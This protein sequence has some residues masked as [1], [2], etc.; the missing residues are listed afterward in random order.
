[1]GTKKWMGRKEMDGAQINGCVQRFGYVEC[2][3]NSFKLY[4]GGGDG[5]GKDVIENF[6]MV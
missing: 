3:N 1:M 6:K 4:R 2:K 5:C